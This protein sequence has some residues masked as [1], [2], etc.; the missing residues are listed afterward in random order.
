MLKIKDLALRHMV[1]QVTGH[2]LQS[3]RLKILRC[4]LARKLSVALKLT[5]MLRFCLL[6]N[7]QRFL[8]QFTSH[9]FVRADCK[10]CGVDLQNR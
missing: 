7:Q 5:D 2:D 10:L 4:K 6:N 8:S 9:D 1:L 3:A